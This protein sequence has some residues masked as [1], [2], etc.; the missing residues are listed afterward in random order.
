MRSPSRALLLGALLLLHACDRPPLDRGTSTPGA[1]DVA[2]ADTPDGAAVG[3]SVCGDAPPLSA[4]SLTTDERAHII[5]GSLSLSEKIEQMAGPRLTPEMFIT[6]DNE[7]AGLRGLRFRDGPRGVRLES[8]SATCFPVA[9]AR[10]ATWDLDLE[11]RVGEAMGL[12]TRGAGHNCLLAPTI[13]TL[14]HPG[15]GRAQETYGEDPWLLGMMGAAFTRGAQTE[16]PVCVKHLAGNNIED[17]RMTNDA[18][19]DEQTLRENYTRQFEMV[20]KEADAACVM[21]AYNKV[22]G[23]YCCEN[24]PLLR[25]LLK[26]EWG[27]DGFVVSDWFATKSTVESAL[28]G[29]DVEMPWRN[30]YNEL[31]HAVDGGQVPEA[32]IDEAVLRTLRIRF[33]FGSALLSEEWESDPEVLESAEHI[34]LAKEAAREGIV[35]LTNHDDALPIDRSAVTRIAV[36]GPWADEARLGD[37]GSSHVNTSYAITPYQGVVDLAGDGI[38]VVHSEDAAAAAGAD[39]AIVVAALS[40]TDEG[41]AIN[42]GGDREQLDLSP[43]QE[44]VILEAVTLAARTVV[45]LE[46]GGPLTMEAW[47][48]QVDAIVMAWYPGMEGGHAIAEI[49]FGDVAPSGRV[50]QTWPRR[51]EDCPEFGNHQD[52]T[53]FA[54]L[55]GYRHAD[56]TGVAPLYPFGH[57]LTYTSFDYRDLRLPCEAVTAAGRM[58]VSLEIENTGA[59]AGVAVPQLYVSVPDSEARRPLKELKGFA[60]VELAAGEAR[61]VEIPLRVPDLA[62]WDV[63]A[64]AWVVERTSYEIQVG[65]DAATSS[66]SGSFVVAEQGVETLE[67]VSP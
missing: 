48:D 42:G 61:R 55:H 19:I 22:N 39:L 58:M 32:V 54:F 24:Q 14:R 47:G 50:A 2:R 44:A 46:A 21:A 11:R 27:F 49:L 13:N 51:V 57:G 35:L 7:P 56:Q 31:Q 30:H 26:E 67:E 34:A 41:E 65:P 53:E 3:S 64:H 37:L 38:E 66:L 59:R 4:Q 29:L 10:A 5:L 1:G 12:E 62:Y 17:T 20:V 6:P 25:G 40:Q 23:A 8:G 15:W 36:V 9:M 52:E 60:R 18:I 45:V 63:D 43:E 33:R 16:V 28:G